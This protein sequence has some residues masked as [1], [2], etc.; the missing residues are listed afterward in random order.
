MGV[1]ETITK[2][3][4]GESFPPITRMRDQ[5]DTKAEHFYGKKEK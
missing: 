3:M 5:S 2:Q 1:G 4:K